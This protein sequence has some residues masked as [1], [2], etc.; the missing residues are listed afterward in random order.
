MPIFSARSKANLL[1]C[2]HDLQRLFN[3]VIK[4]AD[5]AIICGHRSQLDQNKAF[6]AGASKVAWP[7]S[8]HNSLP[9][10]AVDAVPIPLDWNDIPSF[11]A[12]SA[13]VKEAA[14]RLG[15]EIAYGGDWPKFKDYPHYEL[16]GRKS[17]VLAGKAGPDS[18]TQK[19]SV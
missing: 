11:L 8:K 5:C 4:H 1:T 19:G 6:M 3:E 7:D 2:H 9:S 12:L 18:D 10:M 16:V 13:V 15:L 14:S 17:G